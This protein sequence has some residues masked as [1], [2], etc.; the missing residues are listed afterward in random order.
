MKHVCIVL[1][2]LV[3]FVNGLSIGWGHYAAPPVV[4]VLLAIVVGYY[5]WC[6]RQEES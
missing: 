6:D 2:V 5:I 1:M 4:L 3:A